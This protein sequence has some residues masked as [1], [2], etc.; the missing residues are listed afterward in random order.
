LIDIKKLDSI[1]GVGIASLATGEDKAI[2]GDA[3]GGWAGISSMSASTNPRLCRDE[4]AARPSR[5]VARRAQ[6]PVS[7]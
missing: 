2:D 4:K 5:R 7:G 6:E 3:A 1:E